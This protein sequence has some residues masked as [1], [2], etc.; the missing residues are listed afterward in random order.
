MAALVA[1]DALGARA[2]IA[3]S[4]LMGVLSSFDMPL[5]QSLIA[6]FVEN[7]DDLTNAL[8]LNTMLFNMG[9]LAGPPLAGLML[10]FTTEATCFA[11]NGC[12]YLLL[13]VTLFVLTEKRL[14]RAEGQIRDIF[15]EGLSYA[16]RQRSVRIQLVTLVVF[17]FTASAYSVLLPIFA[18]DIFAGD[19]TTLGWLWGL[20]GGGALAG[21]IFLA[22]ILSVTRLFSAVIAGVATSSVSLLAFSITRHIIPAMLEMFA[23]GFGIAI[24]NAGINV[25]LQHNAPAAFRGRIVT[26]FTSIRFGFDALGGLIAGV[27]ATRFGAVWTIAIE[28]AVLL[29]FGVFLVLRRNRLISDFAAEIEA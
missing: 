17:N 21:T 10:A 9:R 15:A 25:I 6:S 20:V 27:L 12:S 11:F 2:I 19:A 28:G 22:S 14:P 7:R 5:R 13:L 16:R 23:L 8:A 18:R 3:M 29:V 4:L 24:C 26:I 1:F